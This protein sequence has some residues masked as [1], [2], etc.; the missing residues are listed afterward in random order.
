MSDGILV[1]ESAPA[2]AED[3]PA[4]H[5]WYDEVHIPEMLALD[6]FTSARRYTA[7]DG[8]TYVAVYEIAGDLETA[9]ASLAAAQ[10]SRTMSMPT[11]FTLAGRPT[12]RYFRAV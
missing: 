2:S 12:V 10:Q 3:A 9:K 6:G 8:E 11:G 7:D 1:V 5:R 4:F